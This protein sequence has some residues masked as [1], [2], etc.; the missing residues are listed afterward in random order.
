M[1]SK[2][3]DGQNSVDVKQTWA[4]LAFTTSRNVQKF[5]WLFL[6][7][8]APDVVLECDNPVHVTEVCKVAEK[9]KL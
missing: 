1:C 3:H 5:C 6:Q 9:T 4:Q 7:L 2:N 8:V